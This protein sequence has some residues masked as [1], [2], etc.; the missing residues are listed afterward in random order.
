MNQHCENG[1]PE[2]D[3]NPRHLTF[4]ANA[5]TSELAGLSGWNSNQA[6]DIHLR[7]AEICLSCSGTECHMLSQC[8]P[9]WVMSSALPAVSR[10]Q[11]CYKCQPA[12]SRTSFAKYQANQHCENGCPEQDSNPRPLT[13]Q[14][15]ALTTELPGLSGWNSNQAQ[16]T[17]LRS[18]EIC[19]SCSGTECHRLSQCPQ[20]G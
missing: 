15:S 3:S 1:C 8:P 20:T 10:Q 9:N 13:F 7:R 12:A 18:A 17:H 14:A 19:L 2:Q 4:Q 6:Q 11:S 5:L 16:D